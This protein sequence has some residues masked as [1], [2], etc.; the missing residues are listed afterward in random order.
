MMDLSKT[1]AMN[2]MEQLSRIEKI[3]VENTP[4]QDTWIKI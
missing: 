3:I 4:A 1:I 2:F